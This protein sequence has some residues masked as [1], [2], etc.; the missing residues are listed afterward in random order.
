MIA[1]KSNEVGVNSRI[2]KAFSWKLLF[3][4]APAED[5]SKVRFGLFLEPRTINMSEL[6]V[7][8]PAMKL[9][10]KLSMT[11]FQ[12]EPTSFADDAIR[13]SEPELAVVIRWEFLTF[14]QKYQ[15]QWLFS[16]PIRLSNQRLKRK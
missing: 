10:I 9:L 7:I 12:H 14:A 4:L 1:W 5:A 2:S 16:P 11:N 15:Q 13:C 6:L 3:G 8:T